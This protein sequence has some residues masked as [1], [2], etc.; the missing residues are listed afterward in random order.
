MKRTLV[1]ILVLASWQNMAY[2]VYYDRADNDRRYHHSKDKDREVQT[3]VVTNVD[4]A[5]L[6]AEKQIIEKIDEQ[7]R[8]CEQQYDLCIEDTDMTICKK[9]QDQCMKDYIEMLKQK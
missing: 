1:L 9:K 2:A 8:L 3:V 4:A 7:R 5:S 6:P